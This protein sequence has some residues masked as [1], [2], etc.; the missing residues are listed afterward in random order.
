MERIVTQE[1]LSKA[2]TLTL[3]AFIETITGVPTKVGDLKEYHKKTIECLNDGLFEGLVEDFNHMTTGEDD[4]V[5]D[6]VSALGMFKDDGEDDEKETNI[7][8]T[9]VKS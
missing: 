9:E 4:D 8:T 1:D 7:V 2:L 3:S 6:I 5:C